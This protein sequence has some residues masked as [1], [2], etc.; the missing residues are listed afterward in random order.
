MLNDLGRSELA[1]PPSGFLSE[2]EDYTSLRWSFQIPFEEHHL[3]GAPHT[4]H[5]S[6][7]NLNSL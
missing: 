1:I 5:K 3:F 4:I 6:G 7:L 2:D